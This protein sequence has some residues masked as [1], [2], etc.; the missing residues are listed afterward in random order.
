MRSRRLWL[1]LLLLLGSALAI[2]YV[3]ARVVETRRQRAGLEHA[4]KEMAA[5]RYHTARKALLEVR[6]SKFG[7]GEVEYQLGFCELQRGGRPAAMA[8]WEQVPPSSPFASRAAVQLALSS[9]DAG[10]FTRA[11]EILLTAR[12][13]ENGTDSLGLLKTLGYLYQIEGRTDDLRWTIEESWLWSDSPATLLRQLNRLDTLPLPVGT[14]RQSLER[15]NAADDRMWLGPREPRDQDGSVQ[16]RVAS[17]ASEACL[18]RRPDDP[19]VWQRPLR[20]GTG[21]RR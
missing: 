21:S 14:I 3:A 20:A 6:G 1:A 11:E 13:R 8:T 16:R 15:A 4:K 7:D 18:K 5:G 10:N 12:R 17:V 2:G 9:I 19:V